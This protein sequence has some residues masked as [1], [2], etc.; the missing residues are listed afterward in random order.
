MF[1]IDGAG[2]D[3]TLAAPAGLS[4]VSRAKGAEHGGHA[5]LD[6][7]GAAAVQPAV[8]DAAAERIN[9]HIVGRHRVLMGLEQESAASARQLQAGNNVVAQRSNGLALA[10]DAQAAEE[11]F[12]GRP[13]AVF[14]EVVPL[15]RPAHRV[16]AG[17]PHQVLQQPGGFVHGFSERI[18]GH[19]RTCEPGEA[20][21]S[22]TRVCRRVT[23]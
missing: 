23:P 15:E 9:G 14:E 2:H 3:S 19:P 18:R 8:V 6:V 4:R 1:L 22:V 11:M 10:G 12:R 20:S 17:Q 16:D 21:H 5:A 7:A 13:D